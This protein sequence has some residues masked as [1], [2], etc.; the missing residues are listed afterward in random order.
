ML[1]V[2]HFAAP[3][4]VRRGND[5]FSAANYGDLP[6]VRHFVRQ[7]LKSVE[8]R[9]ILGETALHK[10]VSY[11]HRVVAEFLMAKKADM[12]AQNVVGP[13]PER[14]PWRMGRCG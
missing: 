13:G 7:G 4:V 3:N 12:D 5:I 8:E 14:R 1:V 11:G 10:A 2:T 9:D 6:A